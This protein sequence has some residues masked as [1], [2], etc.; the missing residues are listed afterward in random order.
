MILQVDACIRF[1]CELECNCRFSF[2]EYA[3][4]PIPGKIPSPGECANLLL[5]P[6]SEDKAKAVSKAVDCYSLGDVEMNHSDWR[7]GR[8]VPTH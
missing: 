3:Q 4:N 8:D 1:K 7:V 6:R 5:V 2:T